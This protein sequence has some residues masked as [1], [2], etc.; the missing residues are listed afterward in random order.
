VAY[1]ANIPTPRRFWWGSPY[2]FEQHIIA[3]GI[4]SLKSLVKCF[5]IISF[6]TSYVLSWRY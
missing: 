5:S 3:L 1:K 4:I 2:I 6:Y